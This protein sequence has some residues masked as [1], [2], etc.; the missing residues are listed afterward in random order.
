MRR[1][2]QRALRKE[3]NKRA[4]WHSKLWRQVKKEYTTPWRGM[5]KVASA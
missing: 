1:V 2:R 3:Y 5:R 4:I